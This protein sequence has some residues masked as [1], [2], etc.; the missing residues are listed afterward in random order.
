MVELDF[1]TLY[2]CDSAGNVGELYEFC[3]GYLEPQDL[4]EEAG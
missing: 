1:E 3:V 2:A 4:I